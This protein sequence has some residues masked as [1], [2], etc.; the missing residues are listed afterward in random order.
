MMEL[1]VLLKDVLGRSFYI[2]NVI[3]NPKLSMHDYGLSNLYLSTHIV[4]LRMNPHLKEN[5]IT[6]KLHHKLLLKIVLI[7]CIR[8]YEYDF[9]IFAMSSLQNEAS[10]N[11]RREKNTNWNVHK[12]VAREFRTLVHMT[13]VRLEMTSLKA[14]IIKS[15]ATL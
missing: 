7:V 11:K 10:I 4:Y 15:R 14:M 5:N 8:A 12:V 13:F 3:L 6:T 1:P 2:E 9:Q